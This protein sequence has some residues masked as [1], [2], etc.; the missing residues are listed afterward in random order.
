MVQIMD[1]AQ[2]PSPDKTIRPV[3][4]EKSKRRSTS[5]KSKK[6]GNEVEL[7][8]IKLSKPLA[9]TDYFVNKPG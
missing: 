8:Y 7:N 9:L 3:K 2:E 6:S 1:G 4:I 5:K